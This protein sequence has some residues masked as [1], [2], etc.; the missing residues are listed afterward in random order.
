MADDL[1]GFIDQLAVLHAAG[2]LAGQAPIELEPWTTAVDVERAVASM[3]AG[4]EQFRA[5]TATDR[6]AI[7]VEARRAQLGR[8]LRALQAAL[9]ER[10][11]V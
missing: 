4:V 6:A 5:M 9:R 1:A 3:L 2:A 7:G 8:H 11:L 10:G